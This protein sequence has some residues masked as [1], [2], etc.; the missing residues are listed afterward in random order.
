MILLEVVLQKIRFALTKLREIVEVDT[1]YRNINVSAKETLI[2]L[3][4]AHHVVV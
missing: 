3:S 4:I 2:K 1:S